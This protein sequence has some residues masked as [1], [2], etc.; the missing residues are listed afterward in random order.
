MAHHKLK[1]EK[2]Y[3]DAKLSGDKLFEIRINDRGY[4]KGDTV[5]YFQYP[6]S[7]PAIEHT[8]EITYVTH[9]AQAGSYCV[10]GERPIK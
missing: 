5:S 3:L 4:Q 9:Y 2:Q 7:G 1:I 8:F 6:V 10:F